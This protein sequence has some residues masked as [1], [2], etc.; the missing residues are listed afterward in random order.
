MS[1]FRRKISI[2]HYVFDM[3]IQSLLIFLPFSVFASVWLT[4][5]IGIPWAAY[6][7]EWIFLIS[8]IS[9][10]I[11][12]FQQISS[13]QSH[14]RLWWLEIFI[15]LYV[16]TW[17]IVTLFTTWIRGLIFG[18]R[19]DYQFLIMLLVAYYGYAYLQKPLS[20]YIRIFL[21]SWGCMLL[22]SALLKWPFSEEILLFFGYGNNPSA[23]DFW[24]APPVFH[25][26]WWAN[27][28]RFQG[29]LDSPNTMWA[30]LILF[31]WVFAFY[32]RYKKSWYFAVSLILIGL[33]GMI[34]YTY[35]RSA[36]IGIA[37]A[38]MIALFSGLRTLYRLYRTQLIAVMVLIFV[39]MWAVFIG[40]YDRAA[41]I[42]GREGSTKWHKERMIIWLQRIASQ[43]LGQW[44]W[45]A[46]P[47]YRH[48][49]KLDWKN[50]EDIEKLDTWYIPE[51]W[52]LQ[53]FIESG[54]IWWTIFILL[55]L[56]IFFSLF[57]KYPFIAAVFA[58]IGMMNHFLHTFESS[59]L[60]LSL[61]LIIG[62]FLAKRQAHNNKQI[63]I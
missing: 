46:G 3:S 55:I 59:A 44:L 62:L 30:F 22:L 42:I 12:Y 7:K 51:S 43:P 20:Y 31:S 17:V 5:G 35:S 48:V 56:Y 38:Y 60:S 8:I 63:C 4:H 41:A 53:Q 6:I 61:F 25:G 2:V 28:R 14:I 11:I 1:L 54:I 10:S 37:F 16:V 27:V 15:W 29:I 39:W 57:P 21:Y 58:G 32:M 45:S 36:F 50:R 18:G 47:A 13:R 52:Y 40:Y 23:W 49:M 34:F 26:V 19:Y 33:I 9:L 24:S